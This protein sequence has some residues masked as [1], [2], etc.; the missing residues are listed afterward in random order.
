M[1]NWTRASPSQQEARG[2]DGLTPYKAA[3]A[4]E[5]ARRALAAIGSDRGRKLPGLHPHPLV[6][7]S[8]LLDNHPSD[9]VSCGLPWIR[10]ST[11]GRPWSCVIGCDFH[12]CNRCA[13]VETVIETV[14]DPLSTDEHVDEHHATKLAT[15]DL[16]NNDA[17]QMLS[18][19]DGSI[20][21]ST[22]LHTGAVDTSISSSVPAATSQ[23]SESS[24]E[25]DVDWHGDEAIQ[26]RIQVR[27]MFGPCS[28]S[29][30][31]HP[32]PELLP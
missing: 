5:I 24:Q 4:D 15:T 13:R 26:S 29:I 22:V 2:S 1:Y 3:I 14:I 11:D 27:H 21:A 16:V 12:V 31:P 6:H 25:D 30:E 23:S 20:A 10:A 8:S 18:S 32:L 28:P 17:D 9:C 19:D 7:Q